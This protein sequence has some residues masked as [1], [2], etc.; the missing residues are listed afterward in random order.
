MVWG[1]DGMVM[2][3]GHGIWSWDGH[4]ARFWDQVAALDVSVL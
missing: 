2:R 1:A 4:L 3:S